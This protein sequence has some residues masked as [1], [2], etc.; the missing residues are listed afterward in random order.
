MYQTKKVMVMTISFTTKQTQPKNII[1]T[2]DWTEK[3]EVL[4]MFYVIY[5]P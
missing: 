4:L 2:G 3:T 1:T 5:I